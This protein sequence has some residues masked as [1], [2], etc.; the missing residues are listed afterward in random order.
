MNHSNSEHVLYGLRKIISIVVHNSCF[1]IVSVWLVMILLADG[2]GGM[3]VLLRK[4][5]LREITELPCP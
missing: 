5:F 4:P 2:A 3:S 1:Y